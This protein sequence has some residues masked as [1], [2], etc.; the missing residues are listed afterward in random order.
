MWHCS[1]S[2]DN[3]H[4][5]VAGKNEDE[6][7]GN[8]PIHII[9][10]LFVHSFLCTLLD[11]LASILAHDLSR[12][13][14]RLIRIANWIYYFFFPFIQRPNPYSLVPRLYVFFIICLH[15]CHQCRTEPAFCQGNIYRIVNIFSVKITSYI[16]HYIS[17]TIYHAGLVHI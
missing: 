14:S 7:R 4:S 17:Y 11:L 5:G 3:D 16:I 8:D 9:L 15:C 13:R 6:Q 2:G 10:S 12:A 1:H